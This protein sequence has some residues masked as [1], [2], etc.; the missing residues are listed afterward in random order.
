MAYR[1]LTNNTLVRDRFAPVHDVNFVRGD[2]AEVF[3]ALEEAL[4]NGWQL[5]TSPLPPNVPLIRSCI[6]TVVLKEADAK[7]DVAGIH[8]LAKARERSETL[9]K[10][11][12]AE[13]RHDLEQIDL[14][15]AQRAL[16]ELGLATA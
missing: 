5:L 3:T 11:H 1:I 12:L 6:R 14:T 7:Y 16:L 10:P 8:C 15:F 13:Q 4:Q 2:T 9:A